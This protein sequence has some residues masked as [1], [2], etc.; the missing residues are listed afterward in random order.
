MYTPKWL[1]VRLVFILN[2]VV[3]KGIRY[4]HIFFIL[5]AEILG[6]MIRNNKD[7]KG[8]HIN[9][10]EFKL[11]QYADDTQLLLDGSEISLK[12]ALLTLKQ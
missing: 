10:K 1:Y 4:H 6:K 8:I 5:C 2:E 11:S 12:E 9:N 7:I 3:D